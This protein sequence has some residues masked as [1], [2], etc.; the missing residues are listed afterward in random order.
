MLAGDLPRELLH[1]MELGG[2]IPH[3]FEFDGCTLAPDELA[4]VDLRPACCVHDWEYDCIRRDWR[5]RSRA[6]LLERERREADQRLYRNMLAC[7]AS[8][9]IAGIY[10]RRVRLWGFPLAYP[11]LPRAVKI[12]RMAV[13]SVSRYLPVW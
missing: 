9:F 11:G 7:G 6:F 1:R 3:W 13:L 2:T 12:W 8:R 10:Y 4:E 5:S